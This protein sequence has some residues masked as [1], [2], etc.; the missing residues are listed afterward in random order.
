DECPFCGAILD[1]KQIQ[2]LETRAENAPAHT[3]HQYL[4]QSQLIDLLRAAIAEKNTL[5]LKVFTLSRQ[6]SRISKR[7]SDHKRL[8]MALATHDI[9]RL[10]HLIRIAIKQGCG[11]EEILSRIEDADK[12]LYNVKSFTLAENKFMRLIKRMAG[13]KAVYA[14]SKFLGLSSAS[15]IRESNPPQLLP[16]VAVVNAAEIAANITEFFGPKPAGSPSSSPVG[17]CLM[18]DGLHLCQRCRWHRPTNQIIGLCREH[19][20]DLDLGMK[21]M[22]SVLKVLETV[23]GS[24]PTRFLVGRRD[25]EITS[26]PVHG[27]F[28]ITF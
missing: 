4:T 16:S 19:T 14:M 12:N 23:H 9:P 8:V 13:R 27:W 11:V 26:G 24:D 18:I 28:S 21:D 15:T 25:V 10:H 22:D 7:M 1:G 17:H 20:G 2:A 6:V 3:P 5:Q